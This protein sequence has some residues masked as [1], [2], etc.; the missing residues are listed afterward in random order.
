[1]NRG[2]FAI[3]W[4]RAGL[5]DLMKEW[6][7]YL[8][9]RDLNWWNF[10]QS[11]EKICWMGLKVSDSMY[12]STFSQWRRP[13]W[14]PNWNTLIHRRQ[15]R[16]ELRW[17]YMI[18]I[19]PG[20]WCFIPCPNFRRMDLQP[21]CRAKEGGSDIFVPSYCCEILDA[22]NVLNIWHGC[23]VVRRSLESWLAQSS[24]SW[25]R[26]LEIDKCLTQWDSRLS[27]RP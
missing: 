25:W 19:M 22:K 6:R 9:D 5:L 15:Y 17:I 27:A 13:L 21:L 2:A 23:M 10:F 18:F 3:Y 26:W 4:I 14:L 1:M 12:I 16:K 20:N 7:L 8:I 11:A 24:L